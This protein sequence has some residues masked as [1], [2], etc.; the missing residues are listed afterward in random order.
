MDQIFQQIAD[1]TILL[2]DDADRFFKTDLGQYILERS[3]REIAECMEAFS[4]A[5]PMDQIA[6]LAIQMKLKLALSVPGWLNEAI[7]S[8]QQELSRRMNE[9]VGE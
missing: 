9:D 2:G 7:Q 5:K 6:M 1:N 4:L 3:K 8:G